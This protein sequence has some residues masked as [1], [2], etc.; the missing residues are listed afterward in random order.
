MK[1]TPENHAVP[2]RDT[3]LLD[4]LKIGF[5]Y[6]TDK[7]LAGFLGVSQK[8][9]SSIRNGKQSLSVRQRIKVMDRLLAVKVRDLMI[10]ISPESLANELLRLSLRGAENL[11]FSEATQCQPTS[12]DTALIDLF[13]KNG[14]QGD[15]FS[16]DEEMAD[17]L[18]VSSSMISSV[19]HGESELGPLPRLRML[20]AICPEADTEQIENGIESSQFLLNL[21]NEHIDI[22]K[23]KGCV[24]KK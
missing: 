24:F 14:N 13:R 2:N 3:E 15:S 8:T 17:F 5:D 21:I 4:R 9:V 16:T 10:K 23:S 11:A 18:G 20:K 7:E 19:R 6:R 22:K 1:S 12:E